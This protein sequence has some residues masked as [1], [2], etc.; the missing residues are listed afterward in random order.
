MCGTCTLS[1]RRDKN[2][3]I[4]KYFGVKKI[5]EIVVTSNKLRNNV[6]K[7]VTSG[8][9]PDVAPGRQLNH[10]DLEDYVAPSC[11]S[12]ISKLLMPIN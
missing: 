10:A 4:F 5:N 11:V 9:G 2:H 3:E 1:I 8:L 7:L 12:R 6:A